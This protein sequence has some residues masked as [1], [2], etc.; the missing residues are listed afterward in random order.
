MESPEPRVDAC[1]QIRKASKGGDE[2]EDCLKTSCRTKEIAS[3]AIK[4]VQGQDK[5]PM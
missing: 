3:Q 4:L 1:P 2:Q 5:R